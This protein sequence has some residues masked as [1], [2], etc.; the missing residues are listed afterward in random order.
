MNISPICISIQ[1]DCS[2]NI[3]P[4]QTQDNRQMGPNHTHAPKAVTDNTSATISVL[5]YL[6]NLIKGA[7]AQFFLFDAQIERGKIMWAFY[8]MWH[9]I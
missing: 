3:T 7:M 2:H 6:V 4:M 1:R 5:T 9:F 8:T